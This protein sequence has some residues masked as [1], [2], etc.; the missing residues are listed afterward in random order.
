VLRSYFDGRHKV[1]ISFSSAEVS[2]RPTRGCPQGSVLGPACWNLMFDGL[3]KILKVI[4]KSDRFA[5]YADDLVVVVTENRDRR[6]TCS[7]Q[8][9]RM[10]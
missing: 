3:L 9:N 2:K 7:K 8:Y 10:V 5:A 1:K 6:S 4:D